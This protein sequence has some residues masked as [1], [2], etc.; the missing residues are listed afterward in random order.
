MTGRGSGLCNTANSHAYMNNGGAGQYGLGNRRNLGRGFRGAGFT[1][2]FQSEYANPVYSKE[3]EQRDLEYEVTFLKDHIKTIED[4][5]A[6]L[7]KDE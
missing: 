2:G 4:R 7:K 5:L 6:N 3:A 1:R